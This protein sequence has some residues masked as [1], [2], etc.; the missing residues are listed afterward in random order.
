MRI[1]FIHKFSRLLLETQFEYRINSIF[2][3][4]QEVKYNSCLQVE[5][6]IFNF[7]YPEICQIL[8]EFQ[9]SLKDLRS[10]FD[11]EQSFFQQWQWQL[12]LQLYSI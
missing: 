12:S 9:L 8:L 7:S 4:Y 1:T 10:S 11:T 2:E 5:W 6:Y 3:V